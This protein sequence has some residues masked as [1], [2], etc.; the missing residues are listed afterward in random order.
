MSRRMTYLAGVLASAALVL[1][2]S[3]CSDAPLAT[4]SADADAVAAKKGDGGEKLTFVGVTLEDGDQ[5]VENAVVEAAVKDKKKD[6]ND[7]TNCSYFTED[8]EE[9]LGSYGE[10]AVPGDGG[11]DAVESF[12]VDRFPDRQ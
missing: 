3:A 1:L 5:V 2:V 8:W 6:K 7:W 12:C 11:T 4:D 9:S 10:N